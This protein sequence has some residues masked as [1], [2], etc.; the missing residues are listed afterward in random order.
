MNNPGI[1][2][3]TR[4]NSRRV[5]N[6][7][8]QLVGDPPKTLIRVLAENLEKTEIPFVF[9]LPQ[10]E[11]D[12][13]LCYEIKDI[14]YNTYLAKFII[15]SNDNVLNRFYWGANQFN[16]NPIIRVTHDDIL[17]DGK[18]LK[19]QLEKHINEGW[20]Y[21]YPINL[22]EGTG[23][24]IV[25]MEVV[26]RGFEFYEDAKPIEHLSY[27]FKKFAKNG[28]VFDVVKE[29]VRPEIKGLRK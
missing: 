20:D 11:F 27:V 8:L 26:K 29:G 5:P 16:F 3:C 15:G 25:N 17:I 23:A 28:G 2:I 10:N 24:E 7:P 12:N 1:V 9:A 13:D 4:S 18:A 6:K 22:I 14:S 21:S 19:A